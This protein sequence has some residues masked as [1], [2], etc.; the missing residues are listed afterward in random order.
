MIIIPLKEIKFISIILKKREDFCTNCGA[1]LVPGFDSCIR[2]GA[3]QNYMETEMAYNLM[4]KERVSSALMIES[5]VFDG[6]DDTRRFSK[7]LRYLENMKLKEA[8]NFYKNHILAHP[9]EY[10]LW[11]NYGAT[12]MGLY[13]RLNAI[14]CY[15]KALSLNPNYYI[16]FYNLGGVLYIC[17]KYE[18]AIKFFNKALDLNPK[19]AEA[20]W[21]RHLANDKLGKLDL[22][23][24]E[25]AW[26]KGLNIFRAKLN[27]S[28]VLVDLGNNK[29]A[30]L[31]IHK[32]ILKNVAHLRKN[33]D[34][35]LALMDV[36][37]FEE[38]L[39]IFSKC[40]EINSEDPITWTFNA[41]ALNKLGKNEEALQMINVAIDLNPNLELA[42]EI[43]FIILHLLE[44][45]FE[46]MECIKEIERINPY[47]PIL[48]KL[49]T[50][51]DLNYLF[52]DEDKFCSK[53]GAKINSD[54]KFCDNCGN[55]L[56]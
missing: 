40:I 31:G 52:K 4:E 6:V 50:P 10:E 48:E 17:Q 53:C 46:A 7:G 39:K 49:F 38:S 43:K 27:F 16:G 36:G 23:A 26:E 15:Q 13:N 3:K 29:D 5:P 19:C 8:L 28:Y 34:E 21:D 44:R 47:H 1:E 18:S 45:N 25:S 54:F 2:C 55:K 12:F 37:K 14:K 24:T 33:L 32:L 35:A 56:L 22:K 41:K 11:N 20:Y 9:N 30:V 42:W 51:P